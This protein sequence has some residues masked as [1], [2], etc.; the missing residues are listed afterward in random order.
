[1][2][3]VLKTIQDQNTPSPLWE[4]AVERGII[5]TPLPIYDYIMIIY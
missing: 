4:R 2:G 3:Y 1:M 5:L